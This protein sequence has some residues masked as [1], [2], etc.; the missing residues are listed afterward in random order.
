MIC[1][2]LP[3][4]STVQASSRSAYEPFCQCYGIAPKGPQSSRHR[5]HHWMF[6]VS[7]RR[8]PLLV[9][10]SDS[11]QQLQVGSNGTPRDINDKGLQWHGVMADGRIHTVHTYRRSSSYQCTRYADVLRVCRFRH[12]QM[13]HPPVHWRFTIYIYIHMNGFAFAYQWQVPQW[14]DYI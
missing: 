8:G 1:T 10:Q 9:A 14:F 11:H 13:P 12:L 2:F 5:I 4:E 7:L 3:Y 6:V